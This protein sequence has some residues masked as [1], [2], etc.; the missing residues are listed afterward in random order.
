M[1]LC[2]PDI[3]REVLARHGFRFSKSL[4]QN[5]LKDASVPYRIAEE[6]GAGETGNVL[7]IGP[8]MGCLTAELCERAEKVVA[9]ELDRALLPVLKETLSGYGNWEVVRGDVLETDLKVL[10][11]EKF[12]TGRVTA[13][14]NLPYYITTPAINALLKSHAFECITLM[15]QREVAKR[16]CAAPG[17]SDYSAFTI[18]VQYWAAAETLFDVPAS[19]F[20]PQP[21][22]DSAVVRLT[23]LDEP[24]VDTLD[25]KLFFALVRAAFNMRRKTLVNALMPVFGD[26]LGK[27]GITEMVESVGLDAKVRGERLSLNDFARLANAAK[28]MSN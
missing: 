25:E 18:Y 17:T 3:I 21:K 11:T 26:G 20:I 28:I 8:G 12:G 24:S 1:N 22:V 27:D 9:V 5:F 23:P 16:I 6:S 2:D 10:C 4:G 19:S 13:C 14:A 15:V 7:E